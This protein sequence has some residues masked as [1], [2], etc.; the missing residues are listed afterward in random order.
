M[1]QSYLDKLDYKNAFVYF[2][3]CYESNLYLLET[4]IAISYCYLNLNGNKPQ[5]K[6]N[7]ESAFFH[8]QKAYALNPSLPTT[9]YAMANVY[10]AGNNDVDAA[11]YYERAI[12]I[13]PAFKNA[14]FETTLKKLAEENA[15]DNFLI[16]R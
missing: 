11:T 3:K 9:N 4:N 13:N 2:K 8:A 15:K 14:A 7:I 12:N 1:A 16:K 6:S 10:I 5:T